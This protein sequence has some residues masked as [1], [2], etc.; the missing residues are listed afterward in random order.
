MANRRVGYLWGP[1]HAADIARATKK[2]K[3]CHGSRMT[4]RKFTASKTKRPLALRGEGGMPVAPVN[5][6][7]A[8]AFHAYPASK[9]TAPV[10]A[11]LEAR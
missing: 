10:R 9:K 1:Q 6:D 4:A 11:R 8:R 5:S 2:K 3:G 7:K